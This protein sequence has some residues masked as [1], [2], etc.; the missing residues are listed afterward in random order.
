VLVLLRSRV[1][2]EFEVVPVFATGQTPSLGRSE[3]WLRGVRRS[4]V[5]QVDLA[6]VG[7][8]KVVDGGVSPASNLALA[9]ESHI[10][11][12]PRRKLRRG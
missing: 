1:L 3:G 9:L 2:P 5:T 6:E 4:A 7:W 12:R 11:G 10:V 8:D